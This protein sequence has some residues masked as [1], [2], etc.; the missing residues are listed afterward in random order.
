[1]KVKKFNY[2][3]KDKNVL[4]AIS[5]ECPNF[6]YSFLQKILRKNDIKINS[7]RIK[8]DE[9]VRSGDVVEFF[10]SEKSENKTEIIYEDEN[11]IAFY[12][13]KKISSQGNNSFEERIKE[14]HGKNHIL[15][16]RLD[17]N[18]DGLIF[19]AKNE[20]VFNE[21]KRLFKDGAIEKHY[22][23]LVYGTIQQCGEYRDYL[24]KD[25]GKGKVFISEKQSKGSKEA[26][27]RYKPLENNQNST[28]LDVTLVTGRT[29]QI[30]AQL[31]FH[32]Y[33]IIGDGKYG[34]EEVNAVFGK[35]TQQLTAYKTI[36][37]VKD[38]LLKY[39]DGIEI[40][41]VNYKK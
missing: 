35:K 12:K 25:S 8:T 38:G 41:L 34:T 37:H 4:K 28:L 23:A 21:M 15:C 7:R 2:Q 1:M 27:L 11:I 6:G 13:P 20:R 31:A 24:F 40:E 30:R 9:T 32:G 26:I 18:T 14:L 17:T 33:P 16:H 19:F 22:F 36:F 3:G 39:L 29:H 5:E 10:Y